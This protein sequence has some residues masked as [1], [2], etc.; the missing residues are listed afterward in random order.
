[1]NK[2]ILKSAALAFAFG[3]VL[4]LSACNVEKTQ[5]GELPDV[6]VNAQGGELPAYDVE[7]ADVDVG[8]EPATVSVPDVDV[9]VGSEQK[10]VEVPDVDVNMPQENDAVEEAPAQ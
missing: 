10:T 2:A 8:T 3:S 6:D 5:D 4:T 1:M 7:T 9:D